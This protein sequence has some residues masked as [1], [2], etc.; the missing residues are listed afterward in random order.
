M[1]LWNHKTTVNEFY[2]NL[3]IKRDLDQM[4]NFPLST[5]FLYDMFQW[6]SIM[7]VL[8][9]SLQILLYVQRIEEH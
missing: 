3:N 2:F 4:L 8:Q 5:K 6:Q 9:M 7:L 1:Y